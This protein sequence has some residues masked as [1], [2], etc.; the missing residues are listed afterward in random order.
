MNAPV[1]LKK[2]SQYRFLGAVTVI[3][4]LLAEIDT[5]AAKCEEKIRGSA[6]LISIQLSASM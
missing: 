2:T 3:E 1:L 5:S 4:S 6:R